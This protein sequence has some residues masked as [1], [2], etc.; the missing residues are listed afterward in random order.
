MAPGVKPAYSGGAWMLR[1]VGAGDLW[2]QLVFSVAACFFFW[3]IRIDIRAMIN[4]AVFARGDSGFFMVQHMHL[5]TSGRL[6]QLVSNALV[7]L[8]S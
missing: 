7:L 3:M 1:Q 5:I 6:Y 4:S 2:P 8:A